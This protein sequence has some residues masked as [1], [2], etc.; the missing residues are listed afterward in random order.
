MNIVI[1]GRTNFIASSRSPGR[2]YD[3]NT[4]CLRM[5]GAGGLGMGWEWLA[6]LV[7]RVYL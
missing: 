5:G 3:V 2:G 1:C 6:G 7:S 4:Y